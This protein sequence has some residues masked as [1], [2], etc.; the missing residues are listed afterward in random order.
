[1]LRGTLLGGVRILVL[2][3]FSIFFDAELAG[4]QIGCFRRGLLESSEFPLGAFDG[5]GLVFVGPPNF[6]FSTANSIEIGLRGRPIF[7]CKLG[8]GVVGPVRNDYGGFGAHNCLIEVIWTAL[9]NK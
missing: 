8:V 4:G 2:V 9:H 1:M 5:E 7:V 3:A 6:G